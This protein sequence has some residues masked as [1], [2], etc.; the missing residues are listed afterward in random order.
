[1]RPGPSDRLPLLVD[2]AAEAEGVDE[3]FDETDDHG[4]HGESSGLGLMRDQ[5]VPA[6]TPHA[7]HEPGLP[8]GDAF[9]DGFVGRIEALE[10]ELQQLFIG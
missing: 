1:M 4:D 6:D 8:V 2:A 7:G 5:A 10:A 9:A 3:F